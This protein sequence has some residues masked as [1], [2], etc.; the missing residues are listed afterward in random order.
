MVNTLFFDFE[1]LHWKEIKF[2]LCLKGEEARQ[3]RSVCVWQWLWVDRMNDRVGS[4]AGKDA[5][6]SWQ[7][8]FG[9]NDD[10]A[11]WGSW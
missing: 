2:L 9:M 4:E 10:L 8:G 11:A 3:H 5:L 1:V 7:T 6:G